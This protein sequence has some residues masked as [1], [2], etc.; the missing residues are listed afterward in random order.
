MVRRRKSWE[1]HIRSFFRAFV[2]RDY[3]ALKP[4]AASAKCLKTRF[5]INANC[6]EI[7]EKRLLS[8]GTIESLIVNENRKG[9]FQIDSRDQ[10]QIRVAVRARFRDTI[11]VAF[12]V[13][14]DAQGKERGRSADELVPVLAA[15]NQHMMDMP[16]EPIQ[17]L[18]PET[19][20]FL[21]VT[22]ARDVAVLEHLWR[23]GT[24]FVSTWVPQYCR[25]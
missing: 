18:S 17:K 23:H 13:G 20:S 11:A 22:N 21:E 3:R 5:Y 4:T 24:S 9:V 12:F 10:G 1:R 7:R 6:T 25:A 2:E 19:W 16:F 15:P 14:K 8:D